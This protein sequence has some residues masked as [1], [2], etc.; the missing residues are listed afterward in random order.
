MVCATNATSVPRHLDP[1]S[2][3]GQERVLRRRAAARSAAAVTHEP[4]AVRRAG[5]QL[6]ARRRG[7]LLSRSL[8][9]CLAPSPPQNTEQ[10]TPRIATSQRTAAPQDH[11]AAESAPR[12]RQHHAPVQGQST[13]GHSGGQRGSRQTRQGRCRRRLQRTGAT[14]PTRS[15]ILLR[16]GYHTPRRPHKTAARR[17]R[18]A[19]H[20]RNGTRRTQQRKAAKLTRGQVGCSRSRRRP[21]VCCQQRLPQRPR[22][23]TKGEDD[24]PSLGWQQRG[25][26]V[27]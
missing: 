26:A 13:H 1:P 19:H 27:L 14:K 17:Q 4:C 5:R 9:L 12:C 8:P 6:R 24:H 20:G 23:H 10:A 11:P 7:V 22:R 18:L 15:R 3:R 2:V 16:L 21:A 25:S